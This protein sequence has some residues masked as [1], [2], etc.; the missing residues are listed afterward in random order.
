MNVMKLMKQAQ[1]MQRD[2]ERIQGE[3]ANRRVEFS[4]GGGMVTATVTGDGSIVGLKIDP[5]VINP[6]DKDM[7]EDLVLAAVDGAIRKSREEASTEMQKVTAGMG[8]PGLFGM[9]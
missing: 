9:K 5:R 8:M 6:G 3:L 1:T 2:M 4:S 7:L